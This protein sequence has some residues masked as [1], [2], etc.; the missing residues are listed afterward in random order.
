MNSLGSVKNSGSCIPVVPSFFPKNFPRL[1]I[2]MGKSAA[3]KTRS[4]HPG[5]Q[6]RNWVRIDCKKAG[7]SEAG[8]AT[9]VVVKFPSNS[10][11]PD[12]RTVCLTPSLARKTDL[13]W[14]LSGVETGTLVYQPA[15]D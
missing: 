1:L 9:P 11:E 2:D 8:E 4:R 12:F 13:R 3:P 15:S 10:T 7:Y 6:E 14:F 5:I